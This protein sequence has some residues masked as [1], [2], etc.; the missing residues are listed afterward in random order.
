MEVFSRHNLSSW[1]FFSISSGSS[2]SSRHIHLQVIFIFKSSSSL[3]HIHLQVIFIF[4]SSSSRSGS[5]LNL[6]HRHWIWIISEASYLYLDHPSIWIISTRSSTLNL[7]RCYLVILL[8][9]GSFTEPSLFH[10]GC[11]ASHHVGLLQR[12]Y[13]TY[14]SEW[15]AQH[16]HMTYSFERHTQHLH[17]TYSSKR[18][19]QHSHLII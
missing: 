3:G 12:L 16:L 14:S 4:K 18:H 6:D 1:V 17:L 7:H 2:M 13:L 9:T 5:S 15:L 10:A 11:R 19:T 8:V